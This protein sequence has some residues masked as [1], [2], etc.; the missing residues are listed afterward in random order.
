[1]TVLLSRKE[2]YILILKDNNFA[3]RLLLRITISN[4]NRQTGALLE[5]P[6]KQGIYLL[7]ER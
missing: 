5:P 1:M 7:E 4:F 3:K 2:N 6:L